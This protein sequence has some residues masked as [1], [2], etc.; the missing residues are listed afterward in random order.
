MKKATDF[1]IKNRYVVITVFIFFSIISLILAQKVNINYD[2]TEYLPT[3]SETKIG[4][5]IMNREF[6]VDS[7]NLN[8]MFKNLKEEEK[9]EIYEALYKIDGVASI[10]YQKDSDEYNTDYYTLYILNV[11]EA[12]DSKTA[13]KIY[14]DVNDAFKDYEFYLSGDIKERNMTILPTWILILVVVICAVILIIMCESYIEPFLFLICIGV[15]VL[16]NNGTNIIFGTVSNITNSISAILQLALSMDYS[17][18]LINRYRQEKEKNNNEIEAMKEALYRSFA[19]ISSSS[20]T[21][22]VGL[23]TLVFMS[24]TIGR[25]LGLV[26]AKGVLL[27][28]LVIFMC[29]PALILLFDKLIT[30]TAKKAPHISLNKLG[31]I[32]YRFRSVGFILLLILFIGSYFLKG[33]LGITYTPSTEDEIA[34]VFPENNQIAII[35][36]NKDE[37]NIA[38]YLKGLENNDKVDEVLGYGNTI[39]EKLKYNEFNNKLENLGFDTKIDEFLLKIIYYNYYNEQAPS[40]TLNE[41]VLFTENNVLNNEK[42]SSKL[43]NSSKNNIKK[44]KYFSSTSEINKKRNYSEIANILDINK[45]D[46]YNL[47]VYYYKD[48]TNIS[49]SL[50]E[51]VNFINNNVLNN[52]EY[53]SSI[54]EQA[55]ESL[56]TLNTFLSKDTITKKMNASEMSLLF[57]IEKSLIDKLYLYYYSNKD[58]DTKLSLNE[59][60]TFIIN[61]IAPQD[62]YKNLFDESTITK[63]QM[64]QSFSDINLID[65]VMNKD[66]LSVVLGIDKTIISQIL[67]IQNLT[68]STPYQ[69]VEFVLSNEQIRNTLDE[70]SLVNLQTISMI[71]NSAKNNDVYSY[72]E[73]SNILSFD[74]TLV[75]TI[76]TMVS[77]AGEVTLTPL[78]FVEFMLK[79]ADSNVLKDSLDAKTKANLELIN[80]VM[81]SVIENKKYTSSEMSNLLGLSRE[82]VKLLYSLYAS[83]S[84][85]MSISLKQFIDFTLNDVVKNKKLSSKFDSNKI[86][87]LNTLNGIMKATDNQTKYNPTEI[88]AI[89]SKLT[90]SVERNDIEVLYIY[91]GSE[92]LYK[93]D[94]SLTMEEFLN[95]VNDK[96]LTDDRFN[97]FIE[98]DMKS[99]V[100]NAKETVKESK[101][102]I[103]GEKYSRIVINTKF[104][105]ESSDVYDF[106]QNTYENLKGT[107]SYII[108]DSSMS[109]EMNKTFTSEFNYISI[110]TMI[111]IFIVVAFTFKS[112]ITP[113]VLVIIIQCAVYLTM[114]ILGLIGESVYFIALLIVQSILMGATIDYAIVYTSYYIEERGKLGIKDAV[115]N[116]YNKS[117]NTILTSSSILIIATILVGKFATGIVSM[118]CKT[119]SEGV[120]CSTIL[121]LIVLPATL[122]FLDRLIL[123][124]QK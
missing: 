80:T 50:N 110:L 22:I 19:S 14:D 111:A 96:I 117:I 29:L 59:F 55:K 74:E 32:I 46:V 52:K 36:N 106:I 51:F 57:G 104:A 35:Y 109:Y 2:M 61:N 62:E 73:M 77:E 68:E 30:K 108:G 94:W 71:M 66:E 101:E 39:S 88:F 27:S 81:T 11:D 63:V 10:D 43:G 90:N 65:K 105:K 9:D 38:G 76:Y 95:Y 87:K 92:K 7:S 97:D 119:L 114:G 69:F 21:T 84:K 60:A 70:S 91:Y 34:K 31:N 44:L 124:H 40:M 45:N 58:I 93:D 79:N 17:I 123:K 112:L 28:L 25:D 41:F 54:S 103:V 47:F 115:K 4:M 26:L 121:I 89:I 102:K 5:N 15:A 85:S 83:N 82:D 24:F 120:I 1:I 18:M 99:K 86:T 20:I 64:L 8:I 56:K 122:S 72:K 12:S 100:E 3:S 49:L 23:V 37:K 107:E 113:L 42:F 116:A 67:S 16:L 6:E 98:D 48:K 78:E 75:K 118:L 33:N 53:S 13:A